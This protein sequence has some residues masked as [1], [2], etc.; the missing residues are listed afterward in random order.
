MES[1]RQLSLGKLRGKLKT[2]LKKYKELEDVVIFGSFV[3]DKSKPNDIDVA[4]IMYEKNYDIAAEIKREIGTITDIE[5]HITTVTF[6]EFYTE[7]IWKSIIAEG[8]SIKNSKFLKDLMK[9][10]PMEIITYNLHKL[11][12]SEKTMFNRAVHS[13]MSLTGA[14][15]ISAG[16]IAVPEHKSGEMGGFFDY[17]QKVETKKYKTIFL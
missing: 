10:K 5:V 11:N 3:K 12:P 4:L 6:K 16:S 15:Q 1:N 14:F 13:E 9:V 7:E 17:W 8:Y 2:Y